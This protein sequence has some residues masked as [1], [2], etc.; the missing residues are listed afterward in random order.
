[1]VMVMAGTNVFA[2]T[3]VPAPLR[4]YL[5]TSYNP[6]CIRVADGADADCVDADVDTKG[7]RLTAKFILLPP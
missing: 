6:M 7:P 5:G 1:M 4:R 3:K 2:D